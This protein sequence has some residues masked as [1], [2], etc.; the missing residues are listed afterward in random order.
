MISQRQD[1]HEIFHPQLVRNR[2]KDAR[3]YRLALF[4][5]YNNGILIKPN[6]APIAALSVHRS[7]NNHTIHDLA[8][9]HL[10]AR[11]CVL[12][13]GDDEVAELP[14]LAAAQNLDA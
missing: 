7:T 13:G 6:F 10:A 5:H 2:A 9:L 12:D 11:D 4:I 1:F 8:L 14:V 3:P